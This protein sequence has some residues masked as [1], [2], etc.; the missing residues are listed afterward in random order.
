MKNFIGSLNIQ[1]ESFKYYLVN[2]NKIIIDNLKIKCITTPGHTKCS[3]CYLLDDNLFTG[4]T[5]FDRSVGRTDFPTGNS[6]EL[7]ES[8]KKILKF[9]INFTIYPGHNNSST[10]EEQKIKN[11]YLQF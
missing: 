9:N 1:Q 8:L 6:L 2:D 7:R 5:L 4:D 11:Y 10:I 3:V